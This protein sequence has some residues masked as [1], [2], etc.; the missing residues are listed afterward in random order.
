MAFEAN[1]HD[2]A[3]STMNVAFGPS[4]LAALRFPLSP[5]GRGRF[6][7]LSRYAVTKSRESAMSLNITSPFANSGSYSANSPFSNPFQRLH[8]SHTVG[9]L[10]QDCDLERVVCAAGQ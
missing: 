7:S 8:C 4:S 2:E 5:G 10:L 6:S 3:W 9:Q 1:G